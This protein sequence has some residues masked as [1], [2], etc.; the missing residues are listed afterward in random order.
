[1]RLYLD[2]AKL[3]DIR[4]LWSWGAFA[5][6][7]TD[8]I[9]LARA[10]LSTEAAVASLGE[11]QNGDVFVQLSGDEPDLLEQRVRE[12]E[13]RLPSRTMFKLPPTPAGLAV[14]HR[15]RDERIWT[16]ATALCSLGQGLLA[17]GAGA[18]IL[19]PFFSRIAEEGRDPVQVVGDII[20]HTALRSGRP[21]VLVA[22]LET[23]EQVLTVARLGAWGAALKPALAEEL[24]VDSGSQAALEQL[25][26]ARIALETPELDAQGE[27]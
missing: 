3:D 10:S 13:S 21:R 18:D 22:S 4:R 6:I 5:G 27:E 8:P 23:V 16:A 24:L 25:D 14:M 1:M 15:L 11:G 7:T 2:T 12:L 19:I 20:E 17:A 9:L 26:A